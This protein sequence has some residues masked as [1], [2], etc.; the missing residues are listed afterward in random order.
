V[1]TLFEFCSQDDD[2]NISLTVS[3]MVV[4][5]NIKNRGLTV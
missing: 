4:Y 3:V 5:S 1:D 2:L